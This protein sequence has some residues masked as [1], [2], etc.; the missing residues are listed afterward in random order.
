MPYKK[1]GLLLG[2][3][4]GRELLGGAGATKLGTEPLLS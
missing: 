1:A 4:A 3:S 2:H